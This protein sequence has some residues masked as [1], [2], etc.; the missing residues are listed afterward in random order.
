MAKTRSTHEH[1]T[2]YTADNKD[3]KNKTK[4]VQTASDNLKNKLKQLGAQLAAFFAVRQILKWGKEFVQAFDKQIQAEKKLS[5][6]IR[7]NGEAVQSTLADYKKWA[8]ELQKV[9]TVGDETTLEMLQVA[10]SM[11]VTGDNAKTAVKEAIALGKA[12]GM[13]EK[14]AIRYTVALQQGNAT[15][16]KRYLPSLY[17][18]E[19]GAEMTAKAHELLGNMFSIVT[20]E[21]KQG[22]GPMKQL[23]NAVG[24]LKEEVGEMIVESKNWAGAIADIKKKIEEATEVLGDYN[25]VK[26]SEEIEENTKWWQKLLIRTATYTKKGREQLSVLA[27]QVTEL[28]KVKDKTGKVDKEQ[29]KQIITIDSLNEQLKMLEGELNQ[30]DITNRTAIATKMQDINAT[31]K[32]ISELQKFIDKLSEVK[33]A[34]TKTTMPGGTIAPIK[35]TAEIDVGAAGVDTSEL[36]GGMIEDTR[37]LTYEYS[38]L[39]EAALAAGDA[40]MQAA[41]SG[42]TSIKEL[43]N[44]ALAAAK[45]TIGS[46]IA[47][48][49]A[50]AVKE[51]LVSIPFPFNIALAAV[52]GA[53]AYALFNAIIPSF[54]EGGAAFGPTLALV[55]EAAG[56]SRNNPEYIGTARQIEQMRGGDKR[57]GTLSVRISRGDMVFFLNE[58]KDYMD[59]SF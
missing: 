31:K 36:M 32:Q 41:M 44:A 40:M 51:A 53:A 1:G 38:M 19:E 28:E 11:G 13:S 58:G 2:R 33:E 37:E 15:M 21:A 47:E 27:D 30:I 43:A 29:I 7:A 45:K 34:V 54:A 35:G 48:G 55:G 59:K 6:A 16:L 22:L 8:S 12:M 23:K 3:F 14:S 57:Q 56:V 39:E 50:G 52:A 26:Q 18:V 9:S 17:A 20:E 49:V 42:K 24:D 5:A 10:Q 46:Y 25:I 4:Q